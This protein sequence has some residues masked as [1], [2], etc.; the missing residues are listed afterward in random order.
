MIE[1]AATGGFG[2]LEHP[3]EPDDLPGGSVDIPG[4]QRLCF[5]Q[6]LMGAPTPKPTDLVAINMTVLFHLRQRRV[7]VELPPEKAVGQNDLGHWK[8]TVVKYPPSVCMA[9]ATV[10]TCGHSIHPGL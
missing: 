6:G 10:V 5:S 7:R 3:A 1:I 2:I 9:F 4:A 8:T